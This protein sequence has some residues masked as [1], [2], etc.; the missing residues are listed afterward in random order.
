MTEI[1]GLLTFGIVFSLCVIIVGIVL[2]SKDVRSKLF[3]ILLVLCGVAMMSNALCFGGT[4]LKKQES[5][6][7]ESSTG[8]IP[9]TIIVNGHTYKLAE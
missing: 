2:W 7:G 6:I 8:D 5:S 3:S 1:I 9:Y 4:L